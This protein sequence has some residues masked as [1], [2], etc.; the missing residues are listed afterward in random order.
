MD[1]SIIKPAF[2]ESKPQRKKIKAFVIANKLISG[3]LIVSLVPPIL[4]MMT[5]IFGLEYVED[6]FSTVK[7]IIERKKIGKYKIYYKVY[8]KNSKKADNIYD[9]DKYLAWAEYFNA[10]REAYVNLL[11]RKTSDE[12][13][14]FYHHNSS[15]KDDVFIEDKNY[16]ND[17]LTNSLLAAEFKMLSSMASLDNEVNIYF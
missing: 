10:I 4:I 15:F 16:A 2:K 3:A 14:S 7:F 13:K 1:N 17:N 6:S 12:L 5:P 11:A 8:L 9:M